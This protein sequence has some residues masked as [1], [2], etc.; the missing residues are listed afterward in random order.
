M[1]LAAKN[2]T[3]LDD[4]TPEHWK[5]HLSA[6]KICDTLGDPE[7]P[8]S[9]T[10]IICPF[11]ILID[12]AEQQPFSFQGLRTDANQGNRPLIVP[13]TW[14]PLG[15]GDESLG[16]YSLDGY[17]GRIH[18][19]RKSMADC[20]ST[21]LGWGGR[22][23]R[24]KVELENLSKIDAAMVIVEC[25]LEQ[26]L[27]SAP[28]HKKSAS[29]N[30]KILHRSIISFAQDYRVPWFFADSRRL[31]EQTTFRFFE[32]YWRKQRELEKQTEKELAELS[33]EDLLAAL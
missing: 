8:D 27:I 19:E 13:T 10:S 26:L 24:F 20:H 9:D 30:A 31:A 12:S 2:L 22:R 11:T 25:S 17:I 16:D 4:Q 33:P 23:E 28:A 29:E 14:K 5:Q 3:L 6:V 15:R 21:I 7:E 18:V 1:L 32:R